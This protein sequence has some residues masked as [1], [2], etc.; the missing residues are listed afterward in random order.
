MSLE[1]LC[2]WNARRGRPSLERLE[3]RLAP[4]VINVVST[5]DNT[6]PVVTAGH[7]GTDA[8]PFVAPSLRSA[9]SFANTHAG[10]NSI[11]LTVPGTYQITLHGAGEDSNASGDLDILPVGGNLTIANNSGGPAAV[12]GGGLDRVFDINPADVTDPASAIVV[13]FQGFTIQDGLASPGDLAPGSGGAIR[14]QGDTSLILDGMTITSN[15]AT[16]DG[17]AIAMENAGGST[18]WTLTVNNSFIGNNHAGDAG[19]GIETDGKGKVFLNPGTEIQGNTCVNQG[20]A[21]WLDPITGAVDS[22]TVANGGSNYVQVPNVV[23]SG[24]GGSGAA[25]F[26]TV[27]GAGHVTGVTITSSGSGYTSAPTVTLSSS[28]G[29]GATATAAVVDFQGASLTM[30]GVLVAGNTALAGP[31]GAIG[32]GGNGAVTITN[33]TVENNYSGGTGGGLGDE[34]NA[35]TLTVTASLFQ[36]NS[37]AGNGGAIQEGGPST[38]ITCTLIRGNNSGGDGGGLFADG[39]T[40]T[41]TGSTVTGNTAAGNGGG[42]EVQTTG[43]AAAFSSIDNT[44]IA[45][46]SILNGN[47][48]NSGGGIDAPSGFTGV[49][50]LV[51]DTIT[52]NFASSGGGVSWAGTTGSTFSVR[53]TIIA[54]N[55]AGAAPDASGLGFSDGGGNLVGITGSAGGNS[56]FTATTT[57]TGTFANPLD[58]QLGPLQNNGGATV[59]SATAPGTLLTEAPVPGSPVL[60]K[61]VNGMVP[62]TTDERGYRRPASGTGNPAVGALELLTPQE[63]FVQALYQDEL[64]RAG[65]TP[66]L[67][68]WVGALKGPGGQQAVVSGILNSPEAQ[69]HLVKGWYITY[70]G[71]QASG[72]EEQG[73]VNLLQAGQAEEQVL[74]MVLGSSEFAGHAQTLFSSGTAQQRVVLALYQLLLN[75]TPSPAELGAQV[76]GLASMGQQSLALAFLQS[77]EYRRDTIA[78]DYVSLLHRGHD[79]MALDNWVFSGLDLGTFRLDFEASAEFFANG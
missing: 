55:S 32:N 4:A 53:N 27:D 35:G 67:D 14:A 48:G 45:G 16:A 42:V 63:R 22:V 74:S 47:G 19:G 5:A 8:D 3:D 33:C 71:R 76:G 15:S 30:T 39:T 36:N 70:L 52:G 66:E 31:T 49:L 61:G 25:G 24:G 56:G 77:Q 18:P 1:S 60:D 10:G 51:N 23:F 50:F 11:N 28:T 72:G 46:N 43:T 34:N 9:I 37:A 26:A 65:A 38:T 41:L 7:A 6:N 69:D 79:A 78:G 2:R 68:G 57:Q 64:G 73:F 54:R 17:G 44:T 58:P 20:A 59:G 13:T 29:T 40:L 21:V 12:D 62:L 75:R